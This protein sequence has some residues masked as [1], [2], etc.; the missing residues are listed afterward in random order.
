MI[1][2]PSPSAL[3]P[4]GPVE[5]LQELIRFDTTNPPGN[6]KPCIEYIKGLMDEAG[7][8]TR[9]IARSPERPNLIA[10]MRGDN[11]QPPF[12][13]YG[14]VDVVTANR[15]S[16]Q[17]P[18]FEGK[19]IDGWVWGRGAL[20]MKSGMAMMISAILKARSEGFV[21]AGDIV[22]AALSD[23]ENSGDYGAKFLVENHPECF[24]GIRFAIGEFGG[25]SMTISGRTFY[26]VQVSEKQTCWIRAVM[27]GPGGHGAMPVKGSAMSRMARFICN[28]DRKPL[29]VRITPPAR[30]M[31]ETLADAL[32]GPLALL[33]RRMLN[34]R[35]T[36]LILS[37]MGEHGNLFRP[38]LRNTA[39]PTIVAGG[40]KIN[41]IPGEI[42][43]HLDGRLVPGGTPEEFIGQ[44]QKI[45]G[46]DIDFEVI[47]H[48]PGPAKPDMGMFDLLSSIVREADPGATTFPMLLP[49]VTDGRFFSRL[50]IQTY[51]FLP[52][53]LPS[54]FRYFT[55]IHNSDERVPADAVEFGT[56]AIHRLI[57]LYG[58]I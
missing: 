33:I 38:L 1:P 19:L 22:F 45:A 12:M 42:I 32:P 58:S 16:W 48:D 25:A 8:E 23:E 53:K 5:I 14:H 51:G 41:V 28:L 21:P 43:L 24:A 39:N 36:D 30:K 47:R 52:L 15:Q 2:A 18:P 35:L 11:R 4:P 46:R 37:T 9:I 40:E 27:H 56:R 3:S 6:E 49:G 10:R 7:L 29:P 26:P 31:I 34:P 54:D 13:M 57:R 50:G 17:H 55:L 20:D 44:L